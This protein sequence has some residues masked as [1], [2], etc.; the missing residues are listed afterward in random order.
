MGEFGSDKNFPI[1]KSPSSKPLLGGA[2]VGPDGAAGIDA[3]FVASQANNILIPSDFDGGNPVLTNAITEFEIWRGNTLL[4]TKSSLDGWTSQVIATNGVSI[5][6][7]T[8]LEATVTVITQDEADFVMQFDKVGFTSITA[9]I[10]VKKVKDG[11]KGDTGDTG[12]AGGTGPTGGVGPTGAD[13]TGL[14]VVKK[15]NQYAWLFIF[16]IWCNKFRWS[17]I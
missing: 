14:V 5:D 13:G 8:D 17:F 7:T 9:K 3:V 16:S 1:K 4:A 2:N 6:D 10:Y 12:A 11:E 15:R